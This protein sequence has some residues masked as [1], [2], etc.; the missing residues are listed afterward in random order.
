MCLESNSVLSGCSNSLP[1]IFR[2]G[3]QWALFFK[4]IPSSAPHNLF[5]FRGFLISNFCQGLEEIVRS[6]GL[7][8]FHV[9]P[10]EAPRCRHWV[11]HLLVLPH[12]VGLFTSSGLSLTTLWHGGDRSAHLT[13]SLWDPGAKRLVA[14]TSAVWSSFVS[15]RIVQMRWFTESFNLGILRKE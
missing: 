10:S 4:N 5:S 2:T 13:V 7:L 3:S 14:C 1:N 15:A 6:T 8:W 9:V 12:R 11:Q